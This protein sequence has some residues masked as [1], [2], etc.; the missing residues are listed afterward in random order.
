MVVN[1]APRR[2]GDDEIG[3][4][5]AVLALFGELVMRVERCVQDFGLF[6]GASSVPARRRDLGARGGP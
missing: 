1:N 3:D 5:E 2:G 6:Q 4:G